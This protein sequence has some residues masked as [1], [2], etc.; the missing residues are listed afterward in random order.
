MSYEGGI[1]FRRLEKKTA[2]KENP[3]ALQE[4]FNLGL[5]AVSR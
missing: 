1:F 5:K 3:E 4:A 2:A